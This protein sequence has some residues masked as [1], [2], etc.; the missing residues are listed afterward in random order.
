MPCHCS[1]IFGLK[2]RKVQNLEAFSIREL[3]QYII[4]LEHSNF[5]LKFLSLVVATVLVANVGIFIAYD[6]SIM[7]IVVSMTLFFI[8]VYGA[9]VILMQKPKLVS[10]FA[11]M[12]LAGFGLINLIKF[13]WRL[14]D[15]QDFID[16]YCGKNENFSAS[17]MRRS[18]LGLFYLICINIINFVFLLTSWYLLKKYINNLYELQRCTKEQKLRLKDPNVRLTLNDSIQIIPNNDKSPI[19]SPDFNP[20]SE[21]ADSAEEPNN[22][23]DEESPVA[24]EI[25][26]PVES[27][28]EDPVEPENEKPSGEIQR[29]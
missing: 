22:Q 23:P 2:P 19:I 18:T 17:C 15:K 16:F 9:G 3:M 6:L 14:I 27:E 7:E 20:K 24:L 26:N 4:R 12:F 13:L 28:K 21:K 25:E 11:W 29:E 1:D 5:L 10:S 8:G